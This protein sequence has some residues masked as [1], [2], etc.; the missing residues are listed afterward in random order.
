MFSIAN[1]LDRSLSRGSIVSDY[2]LAKVIGITHQAISGYRTGLALPKDKVIA[3]LCA[4]SGDDPHLILA[5]IQ[6]ERASSPEAKNLWQT[7]ILRLS[8]GTSTAILSVLF[9]IGA[10]ASTSNDAR[11]SDSQ[12]QN[13]S[14]MDSLYIVFTAMLSGWL[15]LSARWRTAAGRQAMITLARLVTL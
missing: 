13:T 14:F 15:C 12:P 11:A 6:A 4:L 1:L 8:A 9:A 3:Q 5:Q 2:Q 10:I 7:L